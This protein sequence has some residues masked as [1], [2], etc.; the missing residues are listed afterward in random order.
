MRTLQ[1]GLEISID[2]IFKALND[3]KNQHG[4]SEMHL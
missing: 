1:L 2:G 3:I 4:K